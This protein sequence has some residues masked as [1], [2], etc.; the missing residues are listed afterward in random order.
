M[1]SRKIVHV[2]QRE[3]CDPGKSPNA[4]VGQITIDIRIVYPPHIDRM[5]AHRLFQEAVG[6]A[7]SR[8]FDDDC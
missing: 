8:L 5:D 7:E 3:V 6:R 1:S 2:V 4:Y